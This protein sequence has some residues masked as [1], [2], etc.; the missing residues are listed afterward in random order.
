MDGVIK[1]GLSDFYAGYEQREGVI[2]GAVGHPSG[3]K[4]GQG[5]EVRG[6]LYAVATLAMAGIEVRNWFCFLPTLP[7]TSCMTLACHSPS[8]SL[9][10]LIYKTDMMIGLD[11]FEQHG[12][13]LVIN[14]H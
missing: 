2:W 11:N 8:L 3:Q 7:L 13:W 9:S 10:F 14:T 4:E 6:S 1:K 5:L 12:L